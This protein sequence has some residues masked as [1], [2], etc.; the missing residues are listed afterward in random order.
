MRDHVYQYEGKSFKRTRKDIALKAIE[1]G[2]SFF[3]V[4]CN[5]N[6]F[7]F[8]KGWFIASHVKM[9]K[10]FSSSREQHRFDFSDL[11]SIEDVKR[12][13]NSF[14]YHLDSELGRY[15]VFYVEQ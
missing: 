5:V 1:K 2:K 8:H 3:I 13:Y 11:T 7:H 10:P 4:G 6:P 14:A 12:L 9:L 15:P